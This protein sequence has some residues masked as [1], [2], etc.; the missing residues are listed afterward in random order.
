VLLALVVGA[1]G[2]ATLPLEDH[3][4]FVAQTAQEMRDRHDWLVPHFLGKPRLNKPPLS[5]WLVAALAEAS[6]SPRVTPGQARAP[7]VLGGAGMVALTMAIALVLADAEVAA[8]AGVIALS[9]VGL[10]RSTHSARPDMLYAFWCTV[11]LAAFFRAWPAHLL[12]LGAALAT[13]TKGPQV[14]AM[15]LAAIVIVERRRGSTWRALGRRLRPL[16][17]LALVLALT[18]PWWWAVGRALGGRGLAGTQ[19]AGSLLTPSW[20]KLLDLYFFYRPL[21]LLLPSLVVLLV[22]IAWRSWPRA[23]GAAL[24][25]LA[26]FVIVPAVAF[27]FGPQRRP[28][29]ML[30]TLGPLSILLAL[31][32][33]AVFERARAGGRPR[34][35]P[36][37]VMLLWMV[38]ITIEVVLGG[39]K[40]LWS[41]E[42]WA[43]EDLGKAAARA[44]PST[45]P[46]LAFGPDTAAPSY[47]AGRP[48]RTVRSVTRLTTALERSADGVVG[49]LTE[50]RLLERLPPDVDATILAGAFSGDD[51]FVLARL[52]LRRGLPPS[53]AGAGASRASSTASAAASPLRMQSGM[54]TP[55]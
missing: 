34:W 39:S 36:G 12:W 25:T 9:S 50:R 5:Y 10:F 7:S 17:G 16:T 48:I 45:T 26:T 19:L 28:H 53:Q 51:E 2:S 23:A 31:V 32:V 22:A 46:L 6:A 4:V 18:V 33:R 1:A 35:I 24:G 47:Y 54:P 43:M 29:Y 27:S 40:R 37:A 49:L 14:P 3:E 38:T 42:R 8:M 13:L 55:R 15:L 52:A 44:I 41:S 11:M 30:P 21:V 20:S